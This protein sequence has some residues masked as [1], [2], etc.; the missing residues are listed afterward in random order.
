MNANDSSL[1]ARGGAPSGMQESVSGSESRAGVL[2]ADRS[3]ARNRARV[4]GG[5]SMSAAGMTSPGRGCSPA[6]AKEEEWDTTATSLAT[7][8]NNGTTAS[9]SEEL[10]GVGRRQ[11]ALAKR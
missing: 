9:A 2:A 4:A 11:P 5:S 7:A 6:H 3:L 10:I 1:P 8:A